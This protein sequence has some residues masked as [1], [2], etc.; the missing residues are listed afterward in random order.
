MI[1]QDTGA[2]TP[3]Q[4]QAIAALLST[5]THG[6]AASQAGINVRTLNRWLKLDPF[7]QALTQAEGALL[8]K[9]SR[10]LLALGDK[11]LDAL[12]DILETPNQ[13][14]AGNKRMAASDILSQ[15]L[16]LRELHTLEERVK[17][18]EEAVQK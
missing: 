9:L 11:A 13:P 17:R 6:L 2:L 15:L 14:G 18:L 8:G 1:K 3:K 10:R 16:R 4:N 12:A 5:A 7:Q